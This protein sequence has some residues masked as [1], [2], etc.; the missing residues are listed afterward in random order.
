[1]T[2]TTDA[3]LS[4][5]IAALPPNVGAAAGFAEDHHAPYYGFTAYTAETVV[6]IYN[7]TDGGDEVPTV[8]VY[9]ND[10]N[11]DTFFSMALTG[12]PVG[13]AAAWLAHALTVTPPAGYYVELAETRLRYAET[14]RDEAARAYAAAATAYDEARRELAAAKRR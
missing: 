11:G 2:T 4:A 6:T 10:G 12:L 7:F 9:D 14:R 3:Y 8:D 5:V 13:V 1:M